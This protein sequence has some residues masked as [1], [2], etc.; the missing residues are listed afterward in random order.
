MCLSGGTGRRRRLKISRRSPGVWVRFPPQAPLRDTVTEDPLSSADSPVRRIVL[1]AARSPGARASST[2]LE[3]KK[4]QLSAVRTAQHRELGYERRNAVLWHVRED[5]SR[6]LENRC[7]QTRASAWQRQV[8]GQGDHRI[9]DKPG[10]GSSGRAGDPDGDGR[11]AGPARTEQ[12]RRLTSSPS[13]LRPPAPATAA[14][15]DSARSMSSPAH[16]ARTQT[17]TGADAGSRTIP[18]TK[19]V[20]TWTPP[21]N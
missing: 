11:R 4:L 7:Q 12:A 13:A 8:R 17:A 16:R 2:I 5:G 9:G 14:P 15:D 6:L 10:D 18:P 20:G 19:S 1:A 21:G 3:K